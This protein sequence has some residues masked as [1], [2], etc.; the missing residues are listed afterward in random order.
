MGP[1]DRLLGPRK[2]REVPQGNPLA[3]ALFLAGPPLTVVLV[4]AI[5]ENVPA[6]F[7]AY[8]VAWC[9]VVPAAVLRAKHRSWTTHA[10]ALGLARPTGNGTAAGALVGLVMGAS[11][12]A[13][14]AAWGDVLLAGANLREQLT[15]WGVPPDAD[16]ALFAYM[17]AFNS[18]AEEL[19]WRGYVHERLAAWTNR[20]H[21]LLATSVFF[22]SFHVYTIHR[23]VGDASVTVLFSVGV[24]AAALAWAVLSERYESVLP[25]VLA[26]VGATAGYMTVYLAWV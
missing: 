4:L 19:Y 18:V 25:A 20:W 26:H 14:F 10:R 13:A 6:S 17:I 22:T 23:L 16:V 7:F 3:N 9:L 11:T 24:L 21:A 2:P 12:I 5:T 15:A 8:H 1:L